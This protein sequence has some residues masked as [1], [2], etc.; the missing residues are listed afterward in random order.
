LEAFGDLFAF[1]SAGEYWVDGWDERLK[2]TRD[3]VQ[4][5]KSTSHLDS[6][7]HPVNWVLS[8]TKSEDL[9]VIGP[10]EANGL[11]TDIMSSEHVRLHIYSPKV[12]NTMKS[13]EDLS[14]LTLPYSSSAQI[15]GPL[16]EQLNLFAGQLFLK[17][18]AAYRALCEL[19]SLHADSNFSPGEGRVDSDGFVALSSRQALCMGISPFKSSPV[20]FLMRLTG[21]RRKGQDYG[22]TH[23]GKLFHGQLLNEDDFLS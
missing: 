22:P 7:L 19:L 18:Y 3:F 11:I 6:Y 15:Q 21:L 10:F 23:M 9:V 8:T 12:T 20:A 17:N 1:T 14:F 2:V 5:I 16:I 13:F 4:T